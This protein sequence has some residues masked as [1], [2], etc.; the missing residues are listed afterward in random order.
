MKYLDD[1]IEYFN[2]L[3][4]LEIGKH[5]IPNGDDETGNDLEQSSHIR[6]IDK[7]KYRKENVSRLVVQM[8]LSVTDT[9]NEINYFVQKNYPHI[10]LI[11]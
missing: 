10:Y 1:T 6:H 2:N 4:N 3:D 9:S 8:K 5:N 11:F 7:S